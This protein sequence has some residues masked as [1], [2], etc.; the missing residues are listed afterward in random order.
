MRVLLASLVALG[1]FA[2]VG[3]AGEKPVGKVVMDLWDA[4]YLQGGR[5]GHVHT[6]VEEF[7]R[8]GEKL[9]R[10]TVE[11]R[12][13]V[14]RFSDTVE[15]GMDSGDVST[16]EGKVVGV[17]MR[18]MLGKSKKLEIA[19][20]VKD[21][22]V[23][24]TLDGAKPLPSAPW[25]EETVGFHQQQTIL[26]DRK[27]KPGDKFSYP[28]F[29]PSI[30]LVLKTEVEVRDY[31]E[32]LLP[33][34]KQK[35]R[36]LRIE[37]KPEPIQ[38]VQLPALVVWV[39]PALEP[40]LSEVEVPGLGKIRLLRTT[41]TAALSPG[42][43]AQL[44][45]IGL[46]QLIRLKQPIA[47]PYETTSAIYRVVIR[48]DADP[49]SAFAQAG[50]QQVKNLKGDAFELHVTGGPGK[51]AM[52]AAMEPG[53]E[54]TQS[55]YFIA[56]A[57]PRVKE[58]ARKAVGTEADPWKKALRIE[59]WVHNNMTATNDEALAT[60]DHVAK[61]LQGDCTE[62]AMLTAAMCRAEGVPSRTAVGLIY[63]DVRG[64][65]AFAFH[66]WTE[67]WVAGEWRP[68]DA[69]LG[70][71]QVGATHLKICDQS[72]HEARDMTPLFPVVR[73]LGRI[74]I[75]VVTVQ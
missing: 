53:V 31:E 4:A 15:L 19:G 48:D 34:A 64:Q 57:D 2:P 65:P 58:H 69:T 38:K 61:T 26:K 51:A 20:V 18:Q 39:N 74:R 9:L 52:A 41:R 27:V 49:G 30:N 3:V 8:D 12:L 46:S 67:V 66:M 16:P 37:S 25:N 7:E 73:V 24:L 35:V 63:A 75:E 13:K 6:F 28:S 1:L 62:Y 50:R 42:P 21:G 68:I 40:V 17:F 71:G 22:R 29:E 14:K 11:L 45:D 33:G 47:R 70:K 56:S 10:T 72:W 54:F 60:A 43:I 55:S 5:A 32:L 36:L 23:H 59:R 44:T